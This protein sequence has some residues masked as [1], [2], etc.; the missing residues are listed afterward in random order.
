MRVLPR[1]GSLDFDQQAG[2]NWVLTSKIKKMRISHDD[3]KPPR[4]FRHEARG[5]LSC[6]VATLSL[7]AV[8]PRIGSPA[9]ARVALFRLRN[10]MNSGETYVGGRR[11][12]QGFALNNGPFFSAE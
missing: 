12:A 6:T 1:R 3:Q 9:R 11:C 8:L 10:L 5:H 2:L 4:A 7:E